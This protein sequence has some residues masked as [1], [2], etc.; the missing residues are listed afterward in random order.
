VQVTGGDVVSRGVSEDVLGGVLGLDVLG[1]LAD[2]RHQ[3]RF[4][5]DH[6]G[7]RGQHDPGVWPDHRRGG[8]HEDERFLGE[9]IVEFGRMVDVV[10]THAHHLRGK[11]GGEQLHRSHGITV[12]VGSQAKNGL[13]WYSVTPS[14]S[15]R[16]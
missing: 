12:S 10:A 8:L 6:I 3:F 15:A 7:L 16:P 5:M 14:D 1:D 4:V 11:A 13:P 9:R 2:H